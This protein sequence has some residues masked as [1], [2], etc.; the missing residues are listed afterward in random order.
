MTGET[1]TFYAVTR[2][3]EVV[4]ISRRPKDFCS[5]QGR[6]LDPR[7]ARRR[8]SSSSARSST[9]TT[10][11]TPAS[12]A[13][14]PARSRRASSRAC[15]T[16]SR[17]SAPRSST[18]SASEGE[19]DLV[20]ALSQPFPLLVICDMMGIPRSE[21]DTV[22]EGDE[23]HPRRRRPRVHR[24]TA[25]RDGDVRGGHAAHAADERARRAAAGQPD[26]RP[27]VHAGPQRGRR[28][29]AGAGGD[30]ARSSSCSRWPATTPPARPSAT[31]CTCSPRT[32]TSA[33][34]GRTTSRASRRPRWR[35]SSG[36]P[37][38]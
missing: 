14:W 8:R 32:P 18:A 22:L 13:S 16:R 26:R 3:A 29:H 5:G 15:S 24:V 30:R 7:H 17:R 31:A 35:R 21:F 2:Y 23:R 34:S 19:A 28:G 4:E 12:A 25:T 27:H 10:P 33:G 9:W 6:H 1:E 37:R 38:R 11:A 36:S 20:E